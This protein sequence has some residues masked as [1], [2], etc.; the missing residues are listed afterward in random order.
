MLK[1]LAVCTLILLSVAS[2][3]TGNETLFTKLE[4]R[5]TGIDFVNEN[6]ETERSNIL[7]YEYFYNGGGV[8]LGDI[9]NDG[10][11]DIYFSSNLFSNRLYL[12]KGDVTFEDITKTS[13]TGCE[14]GWKTGVSMVD[15]NADGLLDI[16]VCRSASP[17]PDR[18]RNILLVNNGDNT[19][20]DKAKDY[21]LDDPSYS[22][23]AAFF[24]FDRDNDLDVVLLN[25]SLLE[26]SNSFLIN[27]RN[28]TTR[29]PHVGNKFLK[30]ENGKFVDVS[31]SV[32]VFGPAS[33]Y[34]LGVS[35]SDVNNDGW[36]DM[37][38]GCDYTGRDKLLLN[39]AGQ[40]FEDAT[41]RLSHISKFT[42]GTDIADVNG[43]GWM[44][45]FTADMLPED[46]KRQKQ[47][48]GSDR[49]DVLLNMVSNGLHRQYMR[50]MLHLNNGDGSFSEIG[51]LAG[52]ANTDWSWGT[53]FADFDNDGVQDLFVSNGF[54]RDLT[55]N[56]FSKFEA[57]KE[58]MRIRSEGKGSVFDV[59]GKMAENK[60]PNYIFQGSGDLTFKNRTHEWGF[61]QPSLTNG[62]AYGDL[63]ND[64]D[65]DMV[66]NNISEPAGIY[67]NNAES[68]ESNHYLGVRLK[69]TG[70]NRYAVGTRVVLYYDG[71]VLSREMLPVRGF[72]SAV[73]PDLHFGLG[74]HAV[75]DSIHVRWPDGK[76]AK[77]IDVIVDRTIELHE[78]KTAVNAPAPGAEM[79]QYFLP[80]GSVNFKHTE[81]S[82]IDFRVQA[83]LPR[84]YSTM[85][86]ALA[87][88]DVN[89][90]GLTD[91]YVG[92]AKGQSGQL[93]LQRT[94]GA[95]VPAGQQKDLDGL[96]SSEEVDAIFFDMDNDH[97][98]DLFVVTG[99][100]EFDENEALLADRLFEN[101]GRGTF[102]AKSF[103]V[104]FSSGSCA[105][106]ADV[107]QD[108]DLDLFIGSRIT[109]GR[110]PE[111]PQSGLFLNDGKGNF[112]PDTN[113]NSDLL[114][115]G[116]VS[117]ACWVDLN[118]DAFNDLI[119]VGEWMPVKVFLNE[120]GILVDHSGAYIAEKSE[121]WWN[122]IVADDFDGDGD[123]DLVVG[124]QGRNHQMQVDASKPAAITY[125]DFDNN[126]SVDP[127]LTYYIQGVSYPYPTRDEL[128]E[129][130]PSM[131]KRFTDYRSYSTAT[132]QEVLTKEE[133]DV[134][135]T[136][137]AFRMETS[138]LRN[139]GG[140]LT[141][142]DMP[143][144]L[145]FAP[146][147]AMSSVD[148]NADGNP[149]IITAGN[150]SATRAR[151]GA[152]T[153]NHGFVFLGDGNGNFKSAPAG[154]GLGL[155][156]DIRKIVWDGSTLFVGCN[157]DSIRTFRLRPVKGLAQISG[158]N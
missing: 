48:F 37:Y 10:L 100:Y 132:L 142:V 25:H 146:V 91:L 54:K 35:L 83:L 68:F 150:L 88:G 133:L 117:D 157:N 65:L 43:D 153:G 123:K 102:R 14:V 135:R 32:G 22:T 122:C 39:H 98:N 112:S 67:R 72:Q 93:Y 79:T 33:N 6:H 18:R 20:T 145:Q 152:L 8:A 92:G 57:Q 147:F 31:D 154:S 73:Q 5:D 44:D 116:M 99:G 81:N 21:N 66:A 26:I 94:T 11:L 36:I 101:D 15:I 137:A 141:F 109:P 113:Q 108:G 119:V 24:D 19:F 71:K 97:D 82:F 13:G 126:G 75:V 87:Q 134:S 158:G 131:K 103:P 4:P 40:Y 7:T 52:V 9:N 107:D 148:V 77:L 127:L 45:I 30:N 34:G 3:S 89:G 51:Q 46:N 23:Q 149:D 1:D 74:A 151:T 55:D 106:P 60:I 50:N 85:G 114:N 96:R 129:Q 58:L 80:A 38:T 2:C 86:P 144:E 90:D 136:L 59:V 69:G 143:V 29:Y 76:F 12:N 62:V 130:L 28:S 27:L 63:D 64:G 110:Y 84:M 53:L 16:Y 41:N 139:E 128:T 42:M 125:S 118:G 49:Y 111:A 104:A 17:D 155:S 138:Y 124:N 56:D 70:Q 61:D 78:D 140:K 105:R 115:V 156:C 121:G 120:K 95:F 47:L